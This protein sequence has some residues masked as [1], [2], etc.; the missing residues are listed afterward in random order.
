MGAAI[1]FIPN[2][3]D[4]TIGNQKRSGIVY[5]VSIDSSATDSVCGKTWRLKK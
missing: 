1:L 5:T 2:P 3:L 4:R